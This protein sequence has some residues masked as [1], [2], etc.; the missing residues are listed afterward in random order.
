MNSRRNRDEIYTLPTNSSLP[1]NPIVVSN[2]HFLSPMLWDCL[3]YFL[4]LLNWPFIY[5]LPT[6]MFYMKS[7]SRATDKPPVTWHHFIFF[8]TRLI[9][10]FLQSSSKLLGIQIASNKQMPAFI[11]FI[12]TCLNKKTKTT[13]KNSCFKWPKAL[14]QLTSPIFPKTWYMSYLWYTKLF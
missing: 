2:F 9:W 4:F 3:T 13:W 8:Q 10:K 1:E 11:Y 7:V 5:N 14:N 12:Q 6:F